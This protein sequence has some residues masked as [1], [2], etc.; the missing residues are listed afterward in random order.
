MGHNITRDEI[1]F[2]WAY[3]QMRC[4]EDA[5]MSSLIEDMYPE[6]TGSHDFLDEFN[7]VQDHRSLQAL[8][9][10]ADDI[11]ALI[12]Q[13]GAG[14]NLEM[15]TAATEQLLRDYLQHKLEKMRILLE[16]VSKDD[17]A[18]IL[19]DADMQLHDNELMQMLPLFYDFT[20]ASTDSVFFKDRVSRDVAFK[21]F[22]RVL[23]T[24]GSK[25]ARLKDDYKTLLEQQ[26]CF[27]AM[28]PFD[29]DFQKAAERFA[30]GENAY[31]TPM[32][33]MPDTPEEAPADMQ[34][35][36]EIR[37]VRASIINRVKFEEGAETVIDRDQAENLIALGKAVYVDAD[38]ADADAATTSTGDPASADTASH[39]DGTGHVAGDRSS[40]DGSSGDGS[41][42]DG[43]AGAH[44][45]G[46]RA[47]QTPQRVGNTGTPP[48]FILVMVILL[49]LA[50]WAATR[51]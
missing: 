21:A 12:L 15:Q 31:L 17:E 13:A 51:G 48:I 49:V 47:A 41:S 28:A 39:S 26:H 5:S 36:A 27:L 46:R 44:A 29:A 45:D 6:L 23:K 16:E 3:V 35:R 9:G 14:V 34:D 22:G 19:I 38:D 40:G 30:A 18:D 11:E 2:D 42:G 7:L 50:G 8:A 37:L 24:T 25:L 32:D 10:L 20:L 4:L 43:P 33:L 1:D